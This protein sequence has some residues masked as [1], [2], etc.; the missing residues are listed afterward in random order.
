MPSL[1]TYG[2]I[3]LL[4]PAMRA[5][6]VLGREEKLYIVSVLNKISADVPVATVLAQHVLQFEFNTPTGDQ[7]TAP[8][9]LWDIKMYGAD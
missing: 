6:K 4:Y 5:T 7:C 9:E 2:G 1:F 3:F 8:S